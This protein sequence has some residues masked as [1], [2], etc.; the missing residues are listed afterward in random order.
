MKECPPLSVSSYVIGNNTAFTDALGSA[1]YDM[2]KYIFAQST[3]RPVV[4]FFITT[5]GEDN[6]SKKYTM[7][8]VRLMVELYTDFGWQFI[9]AGA[10]IDAAVAGESYG[11]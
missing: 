10:N 11:F 6:A 9:F 8:D 3:K 7:T 2:N 1:I 4:S 5:D